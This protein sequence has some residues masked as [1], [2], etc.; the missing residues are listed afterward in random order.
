MYVWWRG[1]ELIIGC[2]RERKRERESERKRENIDTTH[3]L[4]RN[5]NN[6]NNITGASS[7]V[8]AQDVVLLP[9]A[10]CTSLNDWM[11]MMMKMLREK[12]WSLSKRKATLGDGALSTLLREKERK[13]E[14]EKERKRESAREKE[15]ESER[16]KERES[17]R[18]NER[19]FG[20]RDMMKRWDDE[21]EEE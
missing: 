7:S 15:R 12:K 5:N 21:D 17:E 10:R 18:E 20:G 1:T 13:R 14:R 8:G 11:V 4:P 16:E 6:N 9:P 3:S 2:W 19:W